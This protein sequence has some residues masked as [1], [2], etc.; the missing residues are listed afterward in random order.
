MSG[1]S[2]VGS[3]DQFAGS[4]LNMFDFNQ[5]KAAVNSHKLYLDPT[6]G[7]VLKKAPK[8]TGGDQP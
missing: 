5:K 4:L 2:F 6:S 8:D 7:A 1:G 3:T